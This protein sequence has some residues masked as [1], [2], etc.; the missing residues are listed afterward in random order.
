MDP[1]MSAL[2]DA[3]GF[4]LDHGGVIALTASTVA[5]LLALAPVAVRKLRRASIGTGTTNPSLPD[6][7]ASL[8]AAPSADPQ[9]LLRSLARARKSHVV[10]LGAVEQE[11]VAGADNPDPILLEEF[12][13]HYRHIPKEQPID[14]L[15]VRQLF[16]S[17]SAI[18]HIARVLD[19]HPGKVT[20]IIP[21][22]FLVRLDFW[23]W[24]QMKS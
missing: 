2:F 7:P 1:L 14:L 19:A 13:Y 23:R 5:S 6:A 9:E 18:R 22:Q 20:A 21:F 4:Y 16:M 3:V 8:Q 10:V 11:R 24:L 17:V 15:L 12:F